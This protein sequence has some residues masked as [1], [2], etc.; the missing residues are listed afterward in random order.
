M[1]PCGF[2]TGGGEVARYIGRYGTER[3]A[4]AVLVSAVP[5]FMLKTE[6]NP[7]GLPID[8][9]D[10]LRA[11][12]L[13]D[14]SQFF[15][16]VAGGPFFGFNRPGAKISQGMID[17]WWLQG[18]LGG[19]KNTYDC[20]QAFSETDLTEDLQKFDVPTLVLHGN[21]DQVMPIDI[22]GRASAML[23]PNAKLLVYPGVPH[24]L[25]DT[26]TDQLNQD[27]LEFL[28]T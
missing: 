26:H 23:I 10:G 1:L 8:V 19:Y 14:R 16:D 11:G 22:G 15:K 25:T 6:S 28:N 12:F 2:S 4:K 7:G 9:F 3:I 17:S 21:A 20:I 18:M 27:L 24:G 13:A 5:P